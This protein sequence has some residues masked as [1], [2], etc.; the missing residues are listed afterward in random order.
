MRW[1][2]GGGPMKKVIRGIIFAACVFTIVGWGSTY[3]ESN[4]MRDKGDK[5]AEEKHQKDN[6]DIK[7][8]QGDENA[9][10]TF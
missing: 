6:E 7:R 5:H 1:I 10:K 4:N 2:D 3:S 8:T 9:G